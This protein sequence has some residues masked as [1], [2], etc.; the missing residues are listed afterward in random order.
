MR[1]TLR[2]EHSFFLFVLSGLAINLILVAGCGNKPE[3][4]K[5]NTPPEI[6]TV[7]ISVDE[8]PDL[9][10][11]KCL[12][13]PTPDHVVVE[14]YAALNPR[15]PNN[16]VVAWGAIIA[17][18]GRWVIRSAATF[19]GGRSWNAPLTVPLTTC[20]GVPMDKLDVATDPWV[21]FGPDGR[22]YISSQAYEGRAGG[23]GGLQQIRMA[24]SDDGGRTWKATAP[25]ITAP[26]PVYRMDNSSIGVS[27][28]GDAVFL[29]STYFSPVP[30]EQKVGDEA[31]SNTIGFGAVARSLD[32]GETWDPMQ[33]ISPNVRGAYAD[34]P[35]MVT[36]SRNG[37]LLIV[38][39]SPYACAG[40]AKLG[41]A[42][43]ILKSTDVG[44]TGQSPAA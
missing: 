1:A 28:K 22:A 30:Q 41:N 40:D 18:E 11:E 21:A 10:L 12:H 14:P 31:R 44:K 32:G 38:Y 19:D 4:Q 13:H 25:A 8:R 6:K 9:L 26:G 15:D 17:G 16:I 43:W 37:D 34:L 42:I 23:H 7:A 3:T 29:M 24:L 27:A 35:Q 39:S 33:K 2:K 36:D 20:T 5:L